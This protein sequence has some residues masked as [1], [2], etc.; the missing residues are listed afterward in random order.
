MRKCVPEQIAL[1]QIDVWFED[2]ARIGQQGTMTRIWA[3]KGTRPRV[4]RQQQYE[5]AYI[6]V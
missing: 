5:Y 1:G 6:L 3:K 4:I 2:E